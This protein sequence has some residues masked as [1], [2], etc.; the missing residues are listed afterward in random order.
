MSWGDKKE[1]ESYCRDMMIDFGF[2]FFSIDRELTY[3]LIALLFDGATRLLIPDFRDRMAPLAG[4]V[5][6]I[7]GFMQ[8]KLNRDYREEKTL[9][10]RGVVALVLI[11]L[12]S[13]GAALVIDRLIAVHPRGQILSVLILFSCLNVTMPWSASP[14]IIKGLR[15]KNIIM[16]DLM[17]VLKRRR[18]TRDIQLKNPDPHAVSR[19]VIEATAR[20]F[21][22]GLM[23][24]AF[25][26]C[27]PALLGYS[28]I[29]TVLMATAVTEVN[30]TVTKDDKKNGFTLAFVTL[31]TVIHYIPARLGAL[32]LWIAMFFTPQVNPFTAL[33]CLVKQSHKHSSSNAGW[34]ISIIAG[35]LH[36]ALA[37]GEAKQK[38]IGPEKASAKIGIKE[39][40]HALTLHYVA[41]IVA[42]LL[43]S[44]SLFLSLG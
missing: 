44:V 9:F 25:W 16:A 40:R 34:P 2:S 4:F 41:F 33:S 8:Q 14:Q 36:I 20:S 11:L 17:A 30:R 39:I 42:V 18:V 26:Y 31:D 12:F 24:T 7:T 15:Q 21:D 6:G 10:M 28:G 1:E 37:T 5:A 27:V 23:S 35:G 22:R 19:A 32:L 38:W 43:L 29:V 3:L 13:Y